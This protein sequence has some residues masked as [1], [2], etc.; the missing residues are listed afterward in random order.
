VSAFSTARWIV[1][2]HCPLAEV[3]AM[4]GK[5]ITYQENGP[6]I[7]K[8]NGVTARRRQAGA[9]RPQRPLNFRPSL[10]AAD[11]E[12]GDESTRGELPRHRM[13]DSHSCEPLLAPL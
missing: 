5:L 3:A 1:T 8:W 11:G 13:P 12:M 2:P 4:F 7:L 9:P 10:A 6:L